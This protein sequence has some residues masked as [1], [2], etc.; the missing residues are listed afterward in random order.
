[1]K[2]SFL[3]LFHKPVVFMV[4]HQLELQYFGPT[5]LQ[6]FGIVQCF[7]PFGRNGGLTSGC[8]QCVVSVCVLLVEQPEGEKK[9]SVLLPELPALPV[10]RSCLFYADNRARASV[11]NFS[12]Q[13]GLLGTTFSPL[14]HRFC[15]Q[16]PY[17]VCFVHCMKASMT[18]SKTSFVSVFL[19]SFFTYLLQVSVRKVYLFF[20]VCT[21]C[22]IFLLFSSSISFFSSRIFQDATKAKTISFFLLHFFC[23]C[24]VCVLCYLLVLLI[25][26]NRH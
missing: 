5:V 16:N 15:C 7:L 4:R 13:N 20:F 6:N 18:M 10:S 1:M 14:F 12:H 11:G 25:T 17:G 3:C 21:L 24:F 26:L 9:T 22:Q 19:S 2:P 23:M 8:R